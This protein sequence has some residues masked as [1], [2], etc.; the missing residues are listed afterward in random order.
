MESMSTIRKKT[1]VSYL[2]MEISHFVVIIGRKMRP[3][4]EDIIK[5]LKCDN[6]LSCRGCSKCYYILDYNEDR[7]KM[8]RRCANIK[9][10][11]NCR[12]AAFNH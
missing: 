4:K 7:S 8:I 3:V 10:Q 12:L 2:L 9:N 1:I 6:N 5:A 11:P